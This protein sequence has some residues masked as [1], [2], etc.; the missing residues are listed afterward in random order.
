MKH[1]KL[2]KIN[3]QNTGKGISRQTIK[4]SVKHRQY[5]NIHS[6]IH[7]YTPLYQKY[8]GRRIHF[9]SSKPMKQNLLHTIFRIVLVV[10]LIAGIMLALTWFVPDIKAFAQNWSGKHNV[11]FWIVGLFAPIL[12]ALKRIAEWLGGWVKNILPT[13][14]ND[15]YQRI[16]AS[17]EAIKQQLAEL[18]TRFQTMDAER[19]KQLADQQN[20]IDAFQ[21]QAQPLEDR[22]KTLDETI[23][24]FQNKPLEWFTQ[25]MTDQEVLDALTKRSKANQ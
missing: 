9:Y 11:A 19:T 12:Y 16:A 14:T 5:S 6:I 3:I 7:R 8:W 4:Q 21:A 25:G 13:G 23:R 15:E 17:N 22:L 1:K 2:G 20:R 10:V 18:N 24:N